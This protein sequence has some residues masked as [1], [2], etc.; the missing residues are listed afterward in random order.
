MESPLKQEIE[1]FII[2]FDKIL[3]EKKIKIDLDL[4]VKSATN[5]LLCSDWQTFFT[6]LY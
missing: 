4:D 5:G 1:T 6:I 3:N 2:A